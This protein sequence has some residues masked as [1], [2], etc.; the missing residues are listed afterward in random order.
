[1]RIIQN[2]GIKR[3]SKPF[4]GKIDS[5]KSILLNYILNLHDTF[6]TNFNISN[7]SEFITKSDQNLNELKVTKVYNVL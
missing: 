3:F 7:K 6:E 2:E 5:G 4:F 1:M